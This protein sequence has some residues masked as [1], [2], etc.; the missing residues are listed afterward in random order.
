MWTGTVKQ[1]KHM[2]TSVGVTLI[3]YQRM[4]TFHECSL[5]ILSDN[6]GERWKEQTTATCADVWQRNTKRQQRHKARGQAEMF[7]VI[8]AIVVG[9][10][11]V[12][13]LHGHFWI[14][15]YYIYVYLSI[16]MQDDASNYKLDLLCSL[17][18]KLPELRFFGRMN[19]IRA[20]DCLVLGNP[21]L[22]EGEHILW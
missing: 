22:T 16:P 9:G 12:N 13:F 14:H 7:W 17:F 11:H 8:L 2:G 5:V 21:V 3:L 19:S 4:L 1:R 20:V 15:V 10:M 6:N 18:L